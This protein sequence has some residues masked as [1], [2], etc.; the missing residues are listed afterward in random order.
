M[1]KKVG[2]L[3]FGDKIRVS[4]QNA[5]SETEVS[6]EIVTREFIVTNVQEPLQNAYPGA[7]FVTDLDNGE[8]TA[9][10]LEKDMEVFVIE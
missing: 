9:L 10:E 5:I 8:L 7:L 2:E 1:Y 4:Y 3:K 6:E